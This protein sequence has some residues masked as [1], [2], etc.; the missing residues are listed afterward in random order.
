MEPMSIDQ[1]VAGLMS[2]GG[3]Y[4]VA[5]L[6]N[7]ARVKWNIIPGSVFVAILVPVIGMAVS[8]LVTLLS[9]PG[10]SWLISFLATLGSTWLSQVIAQLNSKSGPVQYTIN[11]LKKDG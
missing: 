6:V 7:L 10:N 5:Y 4:L 3:T 9:Q 2:A 1:I 8:Y 11:A